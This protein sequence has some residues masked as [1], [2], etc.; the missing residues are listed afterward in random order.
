MTT[1]SGVSS[2]TPTGWIVFVWCVIRFR[3]CVDEFERRGGQE[4][5]GGQRNQYNLPGVFPAIQCDEEVILLEEVEVGGEIQEEE[6]H[7][8]EEVN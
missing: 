1:F 2:S 5:E 6:L 8:M 3:F 7:E 4:R